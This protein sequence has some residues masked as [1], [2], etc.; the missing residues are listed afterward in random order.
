MS[1]NLLVM[2]LLWVEE[3]GMSMWVL[4]HAVLDPPA[5]IEEL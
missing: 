1:A 5:Y 2:E 3:E 4:Q